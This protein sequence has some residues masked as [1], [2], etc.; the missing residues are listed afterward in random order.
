MTTV[1]SSR[2]WS[3][4]LFISRPIHSSVNAISAAYSSR[5]RSIVSGSSSMSITHE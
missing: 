2:F 4:S 3:A 5:T 1:S